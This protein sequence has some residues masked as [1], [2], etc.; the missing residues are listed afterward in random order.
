M[1]GTEARFIVIGIGN[2][3]RGDDAVGRWVARRLKGQLP[4]V[5]AIHEQDGEATGL[6]A[7]MEGAAAVWLVDACV[8]GKPPGTVQRFDVT[9]MPLPQGAFNL[10][11]HGFG[12]NEAIEL[13]RALDQLPP[14][15]IVYA[16]EAG[17]VVA[18]E[19]LSSKVAAA[20]EE[21]AGRIQEEI[22]NADMMEGRI[23]A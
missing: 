11:T 15:C 22:A 10:S 21:V 23:D 4:S 7:C 17:S 12:L 3:D 8:S 16:V 6:L 13:A 5:V 1:A 18:G 20:V 14:R 9:D 2:P 19:P